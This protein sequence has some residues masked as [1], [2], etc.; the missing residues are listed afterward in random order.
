MA[1]NNPMWTRLTNPRIGRRLAYTTNRLVR[2]E[3]LKAEV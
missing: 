3:K 2:P 1:L